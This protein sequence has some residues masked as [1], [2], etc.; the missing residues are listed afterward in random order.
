MIVPPVAISKPFQVSPT[1]PKPVAPS[2]RKSFGVVPIL[3]KASSE[4]ALGAIIPRKVTLVRA[5]LSENARCPID[6]RLEPDSKVTEPKLVINPNASGS[7][8]RTLAGMDTEVSPEVAKALFRMIVNEEST[9]KSTPV[10]FSASKKAS[11]AI[12][13]TEAGIDAIP[14][15]VELKAGLV[16]VTM[17]PETVKFP[18]SEQLTVVDA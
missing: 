13:V 15:Q 14:V 4:T 5:G 16:L 18:P 7:I 3:E 10:R 17:F 1:E 9:P 11:T 12:S 2:S 6:S 8:L